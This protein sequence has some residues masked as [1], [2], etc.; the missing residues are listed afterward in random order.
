MGHGGSRKGA[1]RKK[2]SVNKTTVA[3]RRAVRDVFASGL[4]PLDVLLKTMREAWE[5]GD[6]K[7]AVACA[8]KAAPYCHPRLA[9]IEHSGELKLNVHEER[10]KSLLADAGASIS[11]EPQKHDAAIH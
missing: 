2:G 5:G 6:K 1:G 3:V 8:E 11:A 4:T 9:A 10:L 7:V